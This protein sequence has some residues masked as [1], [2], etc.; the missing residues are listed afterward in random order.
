MA[1]S[2]NRKLTELVNAERKISLGPDS[3][4]IITLVG[5]NSLDSA[6]IISLPI[7]YYS[8]LDSLPTTNLVVGEQA[9][10]NANSRLY[11]S[12]G[13]GW[14]NV[15]L[16]N[17]TP[18]LTVTP[19]G[20]IA[21]STDGSTTVIR[22]LGADSDNSDDNLTYSVESGGDFFKM[23]TLVQDSAKQF[24]IT[25]RSS[26]SFDTLASDGS[27][28]LTFK[29]TDGI[30]IASGVNTFTLSFTTNWASATTTETVINPSG[31]GNGDRFGW[32]HFGLNTDGTYFVCGA[33]NEDTD[34]T[35]RGKAWVYYYSGG[36]WSEQA[37]LAPPNA[38]KKN[39][40]NFGVCCDID[41]DGDTAVVAALNYGTYTGA[42]YVFTRSGTTW[43]YRTRLTASDGANY[44]QFGGDA[45]GC[46]TRISKDG[47]Y[48]IAGAFQDDDGGSNNGSAYIFTGSGDSW[49][50]QQRIVP[51]YY[52]GSS[53]QFGFAV[54]F[55]SDATYCA[56]SANKM[57][58]NGTSTAC[59][60]VFIY[61][62]TGSTWSEQA[63]VSPSDGAA[64][65]N[66]GWHI[67]MN[68]AG[69]RL[70]VYSK[71]DD[72]NYTSSGS[73]YVYTRSG[74]TWTQAAKL[75]KGD[76]TTSGFYYDYWGEASI[77]EAGDTFVTKGHGPGDQSSGNG[78]LYVWKD[79]GTDGTSWSLIKTLNTG[80]TETYGLGSQHGGIA[81]SRDGSVIANTSG[82]APNDDKQGKGY[83][84]NAS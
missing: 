26:D 45:N 49:T 68:G 77:N 55:N 13:S 39:Y 42:I 69:D 70:L 10:V 79:N 7:Q 29:V 17:T 61:T 74:S 83:I 47:T 82:A 80:E 48:I 9:F 57:N 53:V 5:Q 30:A 19:S 35:D 34:N 46:G 60:V 50:Q 28:T 4:N 27:S 22:L 11:V 20:T 62:R 1:K 76:P 12:N 84:F 6:D 58:K 59:G 25:P 14:Y 71:Y 44:D 65:D 72:D 78:R 33:E 51:S 32:G 3:D 36:S 56:V 52:S 63:Y 24:T 81:I 64:A 18:T 54:D 73:I 75:V 2:N 66:F 40:L 21:L 15:A 8:T 38:D 23:A 67:S 41:G 37:T 31:I 43:T 16:V